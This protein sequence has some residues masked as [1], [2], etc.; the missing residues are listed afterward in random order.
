[1]GWGGVC[2]EPNGWK[3]IYI[4]GMFFFFERWQVCKCVNIGVCIIYV[5]FWTNPEVWNSGICSIVLRLS[6]SSW[7]TKRLFVN[8]GRRH[9]VVKP[10]SVRWFGAQWFSRHSAIQPLPFLFWLHKHMTSTTT[11]SGI[12]IIHIYIYIRFTC[13]QSITYLSFSSPL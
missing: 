5:F 2:R 9:C 13:H 8:Q 4:V 7:P 6:P 10:P 3:A 1:M 11:V 12:H